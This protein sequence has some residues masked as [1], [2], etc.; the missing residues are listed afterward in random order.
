LHKEEEAAFAALCYVRRNRQIRVDFSRERKCPRCANSRLA[1]VLFGPGSRAKV[2]ECS[3]CGGCWLDD[4]ELTQLHFEWSQS[5]EA[6][7]AEPSD[8]STG[9]L[10]YLYELR[11]GHRK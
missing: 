8:D 3:Q 4:G 9:L 7:T 11:T 5:R 10:H 1:R 6:G 2:C